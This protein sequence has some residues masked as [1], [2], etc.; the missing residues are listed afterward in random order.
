MDQDIR[1]LKWYLKMLHI[2]YSYLAMSW[3]VLQFSESFEKDI[4]QR[5]KGYMTQKR[6]NKNICFS[7]LHKDEKS[8]SPDFDYRV[9]TFWECV[10]PSSDCWRGS[11]HF[12]TKQCTN[13]FELS[14][15]NWLSNNVNMFWSKKFL[16]P[17]SSDISFLY[18]G[19][20]F[21]Q[22]IEIVIAVNE[23]Y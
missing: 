6:W 10:R 18:S 21:K 3:D 14:N 5:S 8:R 9:F 16:P 13:L 7:F 11:G 22:R 4:L 2:F 17:N 1:Y 15:A 23:L 19:L 12:S 20:H